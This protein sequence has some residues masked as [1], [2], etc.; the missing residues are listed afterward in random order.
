MTWGSSVL[1]EHG[2]IKKGC[3]WDQEFDVG[4][5]I[6]KTP[7]HPN[8]TRLRIKPPLCLLSGFTESG[9]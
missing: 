3:D 7:R 9:A 1:S 6:T 4:C 5:K 2:Q 8:G